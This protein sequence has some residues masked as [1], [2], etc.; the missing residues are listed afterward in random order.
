L[1]L[2]DRLHNKRH[3]QYDDYPKQKCF[4]LA[5][6]RLPLVAGSASEIVSEASYY[7]MPGRSLGAR[8]TRAQVAIPNVDF[9]SARGVSARL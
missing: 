4:L 7:S 2:L 8:A 3:D 1:P 6:H 9:S 5:F